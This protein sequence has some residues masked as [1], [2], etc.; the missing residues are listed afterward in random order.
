MLKRSMSPRVASYKK[1]T[2]HINERNFAELIDGEVVG[3]RTTNK[4]DVID[5][6]GNTYT[7][8]GGEWWQIFLYGRERFVNNTEFQE[9]GNVA[10]LMIDC[11][12]AFPE[13]R[14]DYLIDKDTYKR[15]LQIPMRQ[16]KDEIRKPDIF[17]SLLAKGIFNGSEVGYLAILPKGLSGRH[18]PLEQKHF[19]LFAA[20]DVIRVLSTKLDIQNSKAHHRGQTDDQKVIFRYRTGVGEIEIRTDSD[21]HYRQVKWRFNS[22]SILRILRG[23]LKAE[24]VEDRQVSV[25][26]SAREYL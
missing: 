12:D 6:Q 23:G 22:P 10:N 9:I 24:F 21:V 8:K 16:L 3:D 13:N 2:G 17:P 25:Y 14:A 26:G 5:R 19:H 4:T 11:L 20:A 7:V 18:I 15:Q 1:R